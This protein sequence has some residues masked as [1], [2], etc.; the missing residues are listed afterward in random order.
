M[1]SRAGCR[2]PLFAHPPWPRVP[3]DLRPAHTAHHSR[4]H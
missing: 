2:G 4:G 3:H 1:Q